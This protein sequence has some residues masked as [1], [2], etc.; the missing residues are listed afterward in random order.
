MSTDI[1]KSEALHPFS[2]KRDKFPGLAEVETK[3]L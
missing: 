3:I 1:S 2:R